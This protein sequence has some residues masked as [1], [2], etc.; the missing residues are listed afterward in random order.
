MPVTPALGR[1]QKNLEFEV[2]HPQLRNESEA[3]MVYMELCL[4]FFFKVK[5]RII[6]L[7]LMIF[8]PRIILCPCKMA[9]WIKTVAN[10]PSYLSRY[11]HNRRENQFF[12]AVLWPPRECNAHIC[13]YDFKNA[14]SQTKQT[15][16]S[17]LW[18]NILFPVCIAWKWQ[19]INNSPKEAVLNHH[20]HT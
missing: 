20:L 9:Q 11:S 17:Y 3:S 13:W 15:T 10:K 18:H 14:K 19:Y 7:L 5:I 8:F 1:W 6:S 2:I 12:Q 4:F 16:K